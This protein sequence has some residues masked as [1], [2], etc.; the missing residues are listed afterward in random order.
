MCMK[1]VVVSMK[2]IFLPEH[3]YLNIICRV[4]QLYEKRNA[5][6]AEHEK[7]HILLTRELE[8]LE[9]QLCD[10]EQEIARKAV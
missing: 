7:E 1:E 6:I 5:F 9:K 2:P 4:E 3:R 10:L 8:V